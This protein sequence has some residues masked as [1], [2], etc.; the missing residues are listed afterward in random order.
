MEYCRECGERGVL[1]STRII[2]EYM[3][4]RRLPGITVEYCRVP[5][6]MWSTRSTKSKRSAQSAVEYCGVL[7]ST[8]ECHG[9]CGV[10][11]SCGAL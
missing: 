6:I 1:R 2:M 4:Y 11:G 3:E 9:V 8:V 10:R 7:W 5:W